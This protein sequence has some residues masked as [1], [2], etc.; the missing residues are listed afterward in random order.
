M[1][2]RTPPGVI[3]KLS[4]AF[5]TGLSWALVIIFLSVAAILIPRHFFYLNL[6][7]QFG[8]PNQAELV[9][10]A[11]IADAPW[12]I[13]FFLMGFLGKLILFSKRKS[14][15]FV[16]TPVLVITGAAISAFMNYWGYYKASSTL[17]RLA[18]GIRYS[19][20]TFPF[21]F[22][23]YMGEKMLG[24]LSRLGSKETI[25]LF[26]LFLPVLLAIELLILVLILAGITSSL[27]KKR[28][29]S[30]S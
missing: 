23:N 16:L 13:L 27:H 12:I 28:Y 17:V 20:V 11:L 3:K 29:L 5:L 24:N 21:R 6:F 26:T 7:S 8:E 25:Q 15:V 1:K 14:L 18:Y 22:K 30:S 19:F 9:T 10:R 4:A 2:K